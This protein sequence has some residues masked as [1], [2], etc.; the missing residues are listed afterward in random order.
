M[1]VL[2]WNLISESLIGG[3]ALISVLCTTSYHCMGQQTFTESRICIGYSCLI[4]KDVFSLQSRHLK[5]KWS[6]I[7]KCKPNIILPQ[8]I[9]FTHCILNIDSQTYN[10][11]VIARFHW[12]LMKV[13]HQVTSSKAS[14]KNPHHARRVD[15]V[16]SGWQVTTVYHLSCVHNA[17]WAEDS[18]GSLDKHLSACWSS[19]TWNTHHLLCPIIC[20]IGYLEKKKSV[21]MFPQTS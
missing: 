11:F 4:D 6:E 1:S 3:I 14:W 18:T 21:Y 8:N 2:I 5:C 17:K 13:Y 15:S 9:R 16:P 19:Q 12:R 20:Q 7:Q 10:W